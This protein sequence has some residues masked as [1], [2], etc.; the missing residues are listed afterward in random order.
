[1]IINQK[2]TVK[3][4]AEKTKNIVGNIPSM[5]VNYNDKT[6]YKSSIRKESSMEKR[7]MEFNDVISELE[8]ESKKLI[9][10]CHL[11]RRENK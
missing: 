7:L 1:M 6:L 5:N 2:T 3:E 11:I 10:K 8:Q 9:K 4:V